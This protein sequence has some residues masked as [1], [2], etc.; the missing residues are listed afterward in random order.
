MIRH[1]SLKY[2]EINNGGRSGAKRSRKRKLENWK[3]KQL[4]IEK[5][6]MR[7]IDEHPTEKEW[8]K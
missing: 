8:E 5:D 4:I 7:K 3:K 1:R 2:E 6:G